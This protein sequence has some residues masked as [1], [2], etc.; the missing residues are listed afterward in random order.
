[1]SNVIETSGYQTRIRQNRTYTYDPARKLFLN[2]ETD[3]WVQNPVTRRKFIV[4][5]KH[6]YSHPEV[7]RILETITRNTNELECIKYVLKRLAMKSHLKI[8]KNEHSIWDDLETPSV[9]MH[10]KFFM[11]M[12][13][14][15]YTEIMIKLE[16][17]G[18]LFEKTVKTLKGNFPIYRFAEPTFLSDYTLE[19]VTCSAVDQKI[20]NYVSWSFRYFTELEDRAA[21]HIVDNY[22]TIKMDHDELMKIWE[23]RYEKK[24]LPRHPDEHITF[25]KYKQRGEA[26]YRIIELWNMA[27]RTEKLDMFSVDDFGNR[28]HHPLSYLPSECRAFIHDREGSPVLFTEIDL[29]NS[30]PTIYANILVTRF[31]LKVKD[32]CFL[33]EVESNTLYANLASRLQLKGT[34][35]EN[36]V[37]AKV[38]MLTYMY[39]R[40]HSKEQ[41]EFERF[42]G[43]PAEI[44]R[45]YKTLEVDEH[46]Q[47]VAKSDR[48]KL[49]PRIM[50]REE[51]KMFREVW[52]ELL[53][54][55]FHF[56]PVHDAV[57]IAGGDS[58]T[59]NYAERVMRAVLRKHLKIQFDL[60]VKAVTTNVNNCK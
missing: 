39:G 9:W 11:R 20:E 1:M 48:H 24:Y 25:E 51:S 8:R 42:Y 21:R 22:W 34:E 5:R 43:E 44:A 35:D 7:N 52:R 17:A 23:P 37:Y 50:Q 3:K 28:L 19:P 26:I 10:H 16:R 6:V 14:Y 12:L 57:Y 45:E 18:I 49:L 58:R 29:K 59:A 4:S 55:G 54:L 13:G 41:I 32:H 33:R 2:P 38:R 31:G 30:Q 36:H 40:A 46:F 60:K 27:D 53:K 15:N 47:P 56:L